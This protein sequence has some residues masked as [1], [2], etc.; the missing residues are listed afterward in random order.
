MK[1]V[2]RLLLL[3]S[4]GFILS[5]QATNIAVVNIDKII[6]N[7]PEV[8]RVDSKLRKQFSPQDDRITQQEKALQKKIDELKRNASIMTSVQQ[9]DMQTDITTQKNN[10][11]LLQSQFTQ[12]LQ[13]AQSQSMQTIL[14]SINKAVVKVAKQYHYEIVLQKS[15]TIYISSSVDISNKVIAA[16]N[17]SDGKSTQLSSI[18]N[19]KS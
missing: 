2:A 12:D 16:L 11:Q 7:Y 10:L 19:G 6:K 17:G 3:A 4:I 18:L 8:A 1:T 9:A 5:A 14:A 15:R 13:A